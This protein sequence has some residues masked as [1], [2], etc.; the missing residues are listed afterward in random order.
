MGCVQNE[1]NI[2]VPTGGPYVIPYGSILPKL[3][4]CD[5]LL[6][7]CAMSASHIAYG[8]IRMEPV[9]MILAQSA[10]TATSLALAINTGLHDLS[11]PRL[12]E[13]LLAGNQRLE[14]DTERFPAIMPPAE[15]P[16]ERARIFNEPFPERGCVVD[17]FD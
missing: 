6:V 4:E 5:N 2:E 8:S 9:F 13:K 17:Y 7:T 15:P 12:R 14:L 10:A 1:G 11:Y 16:R 3:N